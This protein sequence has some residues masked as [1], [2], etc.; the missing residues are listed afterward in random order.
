MASLS[1]RARTLLVA[2]LVLASAAVI[3][4]AQCVALCRGWWAPPRKQSPHSNPVQHISEASRSQLSSQCAAWT[5]AR[6]PCLAHAQTTPAPCCPGAHDRSQ[7]HQLQAPQVLPLL[8]LQEPPSPGGQQGKWPCPR[9]PACRQLA[10]ASC[11]KPSSFVCGLGRSMCCHLV[12]CSLQVRGDLINQWNKLYPSKK[13]LDWVAGERASCDQQDRP[14]SDGAVRVRAGHQPLACTLTSLDTQTLAMLAAPAGFTDP[15]DKPLP[16]YVFQWGGECASAPCSAAHVRGRVSAIQGRGISP[17]SS[18]PKARCSCPPLTRFTV[19][20]QATSPLRSARTGRTTTSGRASSPSPTRR[21][22]P[23]PP[24]SRCVRH[25]TWCPLGGKS[26]S[27]DSPCAAGALLT[28][29]RRVAAGPLLLPQLFH[30][31]I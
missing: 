27:R 3:A 26:S 24:T 6:G 16:Q 31:Y 10:L 19:P 11:Q 17:R 13:V 8:H 2:T 12:V 20:P 22:C 30:T 25:V 9:T 29:S 28:L 15:L 18:V 21:C 23:M 14:R 1:P 7:A 5:E 4:E